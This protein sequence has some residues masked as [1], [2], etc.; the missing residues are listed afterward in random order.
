MSDFGRY[1]L[2]LSPPCGT[3]ASSYPVDTRL[4][5]GV[6]RQRADCYVI[7]SY[8]VVN[9]WSYTATS[10]VIMACA[11]KIQV[12]WGVTLVTRRVTTG[13]SEGA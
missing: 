4:C 8:F 2:F 6:K 3:H 1:F 10:P 11:L 13:V 9:V 5:L 7:P 12:I